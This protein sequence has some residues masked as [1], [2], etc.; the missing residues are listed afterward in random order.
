M[1]VLISALALTLSLS[2]FAATD[3]CSV[4]YQPEGSKLSWT[5]FKMPAK[6][7]VNGQFTRFTVNSTKA[8]NVDALL[9]NATFN[10]DTASVST[11]DKGRDTKIFQFFFKKMAKGTSITGKVVKVN[12][13]DVEVDFTLNGTTK[14]VTLTKKYDEAK[15]TVTL[16]G[17]INVLDFGM[18]SNLDSLT[19]ACEVLHEGVTWP[20]V[21]IELV[22]SVPKS[23][24]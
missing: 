7:G 17:S 20:D 1:K 22:A 18:K 16:N 3:V 2:S 21:N 12:A 24:K 13:S 5:A 10:V 9:A 4:S 19:K 6:V 11:N 15:N 8:N 14:K 23:C